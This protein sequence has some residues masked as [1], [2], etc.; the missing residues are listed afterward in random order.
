LN[1]YPE[2]S[3]VNQKVEYIIEEKPGEGILLHTKGKAHKF[4][5]GYKGASLELYTIEFLAGK[6]QLHFFKWNWG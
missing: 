1:L 4:K 6:L 2:P 5:D 3:I